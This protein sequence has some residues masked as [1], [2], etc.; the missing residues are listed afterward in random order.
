[1]TLKTDPNFEENLIFC[2]KIDM[3]NLVNF[4]ASSGESEIL[5]F[6]YLLFLKV[7]DVSAK[8]I[9]R[10]CVEKMTYGFKND[11]RNLLN[12]YLKVR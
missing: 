8:K 9:R 3:K 11:I 5:H 10:S 4:K 6:D 1:M 2:L 7:C 12:K